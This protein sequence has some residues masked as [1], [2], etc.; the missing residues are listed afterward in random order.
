M[1]RNSDLISNLTLFFIGLKK[2]RN[3]AQTKNRSFSAGKKKNKQKT[4]HFKVILG[5][6][7]KLIKFVQNRD[8]KRCENKF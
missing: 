5:K 2:G 1:L 7:R 8:V 4:V 3:S 6:T